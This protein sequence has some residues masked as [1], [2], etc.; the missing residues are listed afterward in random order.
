MPHETKRYARIIH[1]YV[2]DTLTLSFTAVTLSDLLG[3]GL[4]E[5]FI[6]SETLPTDPEHG[7]T[8]NIAHMCVTAEG[9][10]AVVYES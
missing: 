9:K 5:S 7:H 4:A 3:A 8:K 2:Y 1:L 10:I 6:R